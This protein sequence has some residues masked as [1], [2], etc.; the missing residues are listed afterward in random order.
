MLRNQGLSAWLA[1]NSLNEL[2]RSKQRGIYNPNISA[3]KGKAAASCG[4]LDP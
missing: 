1:V 3:G 4:E 2:S